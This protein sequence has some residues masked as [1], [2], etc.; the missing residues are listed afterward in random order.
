[1]HIKPIYI[2]CFI[3]AVL[4]SLYG[5][6]WLSS[7]SA[8]SKEEGFEYQEFQLKYPTVASFFDERIDTSIT[9][10]D[11]KTVTTNIAPLEMEEEETP[12]KPIVA[13]I[14]ATEIET[15]SADTVYKELKTDKI[16]IPDISAIDST[17]IQRFNYPINQPDFLDKLSKQLRSKSC[18]I[19]H[20]G[21]S[22][23]EGDRITGYLR[24]RLQKLYGGNGPGFIPIKQVYHQISASVEVNDVWTRHALFDPTQKK[25]DHK[26]YGTYLSLSRFTPIKPDSIAID[27]LPTV[28]ATITIGKS[29]RTYRK[30]RKFNRVALHYGECN[31]PI[32]IKVYNNGALIQ[33]D[34]LVTDGAYHKYNINLPSTPTDLKIELSG[35]VSADFYGLTLDRGTGVQIDNV[36]MRGASGTLFTRNNNT[37]YTQMFKALDPKVVI[38]QYGGNSV[39]YL[40]DSTGVRRYAKRMLSQIKWIKRKKPS[41]SVLFIGPTDLSTSVNGEMVTYD[42]LP[43][44][45]ETLK[46]T[47]TQNGVAYWNMFNAMGGANSMPVWVEEKLAGKDY[48]HFTPKGTRYISEI[49]FMALY[50]DLK[51]HLNQ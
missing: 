26:K 3:L 28:N 48:V 33:Q 32:A 38:M 27:S 23:L 35:K 15:I 41:I 51:S 19:I 16:I 5:L 1:M 7:A 24:N 22:Q 10:E 49:L 20:Y 30:F 31:Y 47:C 14:T 21:D 50:L 40:K 44:L 25:F 43:Y 17:K 45:N 29:N 8:T 12:E 13:D 46:E 39:P 4:G 18:R 6:L 9:V 36:A 42:L 37:T 2:A 34:S 11:L